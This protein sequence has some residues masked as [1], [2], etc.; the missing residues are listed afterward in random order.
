M[1]HGVYC[2]EGYLCN[3]CAIIEA[4]EEMVVTLYQYIGHKKECQAPC[5][6]GYDDLMK[7][8]KEAVSHEICKT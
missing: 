8:I 2:T 5:S 1:G 4:L 6:C 3:Q 7:A